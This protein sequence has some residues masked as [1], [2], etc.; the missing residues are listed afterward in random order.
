MKITV[1]VENESGEIVYRQVS[2]AS[3]AALIPPGLATPGMKSI[4]EV[5]T[6]VALTEKK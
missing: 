2:Y 3:E 1:T 4:A 6:N 5:L